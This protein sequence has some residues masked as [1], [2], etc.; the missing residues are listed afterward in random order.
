MEAKTVFFVLAF[1][2]VRL[3]QMPH[4]YHEIRDLR[5]HEVIFPMIS[6]AYFSRVQNRHGNIRNVAKKWCAAGV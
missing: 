3:K 2:D 1:I 5:V 6:T 4:N